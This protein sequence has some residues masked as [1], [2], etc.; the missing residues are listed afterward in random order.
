M[1]ASTAKSK[2]DMAGVN[3]KAIGSGEVPKRK[4]TLPQPPQLLQA[5]PKPTP[6]QKG[7]P[8]KKA[9]ETPKQSRVPE[10]KNPPKWASQPR[11]PP[12][13]MQSL[14]Q[15]QAIMP[16][17]P[18]MMMQQMASPSMQMPPQ[19]AGMQTAPQMVPPMQTAPHMAPP[20]QTAPQMSPAGGGGEEFTAKRGSRPNRPSQI[21]REERL[22]KQIK[23]EHAELQTEHTRALTKL[24][25]LKQTHAEKVKELQR[26]HEQHVGALI[27]RYDQHVATL[28]QRNHDALGAM[29]QQHRQAFQQLE[30]AHLKDVEQ[31]EKKHD[32]THARNIED[33]GRKMNILRSTIAEKDEELKNVR[34]QLE[35]TK[36]AEEKA[37]WN[38]VGRTVDVDV[39]GIMLNMFMLIACSQITGFARLRKEID[40]R[41]GILTAVPGKSLDNIDSVLGSLWFVFS[42]CVS[43]QKNVIGIGVLQQYPTNSPSMKCGAARAPCHWAGGRNGS[44][45][46]TFGNHGEGTTQEGQKRKERQDK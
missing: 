46:E 39:D 42:F 5:N 26:Q 41:P 18:P 6:K 40:N 24:E 43:V 8:A 37:R 22:M 30:K 14:S 27:Q 33:F 28:N 20:M 1:E 25:L 23:Q 36:V 35:K 16:G 7:M 9:E 2:Q 19:M 17:M 44:V 29:V 11:P 21:A 45:E 38:L 13:L 12:Q 4:V 10:P 34:E 31:M 3:A 32:V 15:P